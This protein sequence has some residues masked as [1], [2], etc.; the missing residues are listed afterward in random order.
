M[1]TARTALVFS[2]VAIALAA[3]SYFHGRPAAPPAEKA[4]ADSEHAG[5]MPG[6]GEIMSMQQMRHAKLALAG[7]AGNWDLADYETDELGEGFDDIV[8]YHPTHK[9]IKQPLTELVPQ[10]TK[11]PV[12]DLR[13]AVKAKDMDKFNAA[14]DG[15][16]AG[17]NGCHQATEFGF[18]VVMRPTTSSFPNQQFTPK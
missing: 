3:T 7:A 13:A 9:D 2:V 16:T 8:T 6:L 5:Y 14:F 12:E 10:F 17:C 4:P 1:T 18:N 11:Q 15:L